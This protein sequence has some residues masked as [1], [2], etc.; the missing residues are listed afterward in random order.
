MQARIA[1][2]TERE[3]KTLRLLLA[4]HDAKSIAREFDLSVHTINDRLRDARRKLGVP[5][6]RE[7]ARLLA[8]HEG[9]PNSIVPEAIG[10][11]DMSANVQID[12]QSSKPKR[13]V[14]VFAFLGGGLL[15]LSLTIVALMIASNL[16]DAATTNPA[17][18]KHAVETKGQSQSESTASAKAW[19]ALV[20]SRNWTE[21]WRRAGS[22]FRS[23]LSQ[24]GWASTILP[25][26]DPLGAVTSRTV[27]KVTKAA[28]LPGA[29]D[30]EYELLEF[31]TDFANKRGA[32]ETVVLAKE[33]SDWRVV[34]YFI[35]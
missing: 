22:M 20:D 1:T 3:K 16:E 14:F 21:S 26:R 25:V 30:G 9:R 15:V 34:G 33:G 19:L 5:S 28:S 10:V 32:I 8:L 17:A 6:S 7:A 29:P 35:R 2:L 12:G 27:G 13:T 24:Q 31:Q 18:Q 23:Q 11:G 4:G